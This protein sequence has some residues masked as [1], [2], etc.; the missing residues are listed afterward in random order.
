MKAKKGRAQP[1]FWD[2]EWS[3]KSSAERRER[4]RKKEEKEKVKKGETKDEQK[5]NDGNPNSF[6][7]ATKKKPGQIQLEDIPSVLTYCLPELKA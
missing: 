2:R 6:E 3:K 4:K 5:E 1:V 7:H